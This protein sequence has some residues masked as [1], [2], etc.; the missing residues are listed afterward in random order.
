MIELKCEVAEQRDSYIEEGEDST[1]YRYD[2]DGTKVWFVQ[3]DNGNI[4]SVYVKQCERLGDIKINIST[5][6]YY[7]YI[8]YPYEC[9]V[10]FPS[11]TIVKDC[12]FHYCIELFEYAQKVSKAI[13]D[14]FDLDLHKNAR[15]DG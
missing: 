9:S 8:Y 1:F 14:I 4:Y 11:F 5:D 3:Y 2:I 13:M 10:V 7:P 6:K 12:E 15:M